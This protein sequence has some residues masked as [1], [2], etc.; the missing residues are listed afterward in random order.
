MNKK[1][2]EPLFKKT[3][4]DRLELK[5]G[6]GCIS[7][8]G[9]PFLLAGLFMLLA[10]LQ[11]IPLSNAKEMPWWSWLILFGMGL[12]FTGVGAGLVFGRN[13]ITIDKT[14]RRIWKAWG[15][16]RPMRG[17]IYDL[18]NYVSVLL[19][20]NPGDSDTAETFPVSLK[21]TDGR[22]ELLLL[23]PQDYGIALEQA[24][25]LSTFLHIKLEE[26]TTDNP[27]E[28][29]PQ[30]ILEGQKPLHKT[31]EIRISAQPVSMK[32]EVTENADQL[33]IR[34]PGQPFRKLN[35]VGL[36]IP[37]I[38]LVVVLPYLLSFF[39]S[40]RTPHFMQY[41]FVGFIGLFFILLP[42]LETFKAYLRSRQVM[43]TVNVK[44]GEIIINY[45]TMTKQGSLHLSMDDIL[46]I[47]YGTKETAIIN[48][49]KQYEKADT[50]H[51]TMGG[52]SAPYSY[53]PYWMRWLE[54]F[55]RARGIIIKS[56][57]GLFT[58]AEGL[59]DD[60][61]YYLYTLVLKYLNEQN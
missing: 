18:N 30:E 57:K 26:M 10:T 12:I 49:Q 44:P 61:V 52:I 35:L 21:A 41:F 9:I 45:L 55:S 3:S 13:W 60:E 27:V 1:I 46:G 34:I 53:Q 39:Q 24:M 47:D 31:G 20:H 59:Q 33:Q 36:I 2:V 23:S 38:M 15:L 29:K 56:K 7:I 11:I 6:G 17:E 42:V 50:R 43:T 5:K 58:F 14:Q 8:F 28:L 48:V 16:L 40:T 25:L 54:K 32:T 4:H 19:K 51:L 37:L 22:T